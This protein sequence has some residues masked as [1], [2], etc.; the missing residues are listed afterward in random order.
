LHQNSKLSFIVFNVEDDTIGNLD[1]KIYN[2]CMRKRTVN[3]K[4]VCLYLAQIII[5]THQIQ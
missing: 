1:P 5:T 2:S 3:S 4:H